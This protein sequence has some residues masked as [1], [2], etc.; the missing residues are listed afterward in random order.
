[1]RLIQSQKAL[2][3]WLK[4]TDGVIL[5]KSSGDWTIDALCGMPEQFSREMCNVSIQWDVSDVG[6]VGSA[7]MMLFIHYYDLLKSNKCSIKIIGARMSMK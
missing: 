5:L 1:M 3:R 7:G 6:R 2:V 4:S